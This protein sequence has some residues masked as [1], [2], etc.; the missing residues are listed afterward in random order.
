MIIVSLK[1]NTNQLHNCVYHHTI[2]RVT[3][4]G[5]LRV[6]EKHKEIFKVS[7]GSLTPA[8]TLRMLI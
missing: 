5:M 6:L 8:K 7:L 2:G 4:T 3:R 1:T